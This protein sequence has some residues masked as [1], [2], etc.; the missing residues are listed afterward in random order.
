M[1]ELVLLINGE[2]KKYSKQRF[3][4]KE[5]IYAMQHQ[6]VRDNYYKDPEKLKDPEEFEVLQE[7]L[8]QT[9]AKIFGNQFSA[10]QLLDGLDMKNRSM[11]EDILLLAL[12]GR[13]DEKGTEKDEKKL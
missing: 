8:A 2:E 4:L 5:N 3:T 7:H 13:I 11:I 6:V 9:I 10:D 12:G 1:I